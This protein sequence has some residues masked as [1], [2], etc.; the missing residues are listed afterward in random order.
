MGDGL[1]PVAG[2]ASLQWLAGFRQAC[3]LH[4]VALFCLSSRKLLIRLGQCFLL[5]GLIFLGSLFFLNK[6]VIPMLSWI[7]P[8]QCKELAF[9]EICDSGAVIR[10]YSVLRSI[11]INLFYVFWFCPLYVLS[12]ILSSIWYNDIAK[13]TFEIFRQQSGDSDN[14]GAVVGP[15]SVNHADKPTGIEGV[16]I[17]ISEQVYSALLLTIFYIEVVVTGYIPVIGK[18]INFVLLSWAYAYYSFEYKWNFSGLSLDKRL[19]LFELN[20]AFFA[21]FGSPCILGIFFFPP[22]T[23]YGVLA[24]LFPLFILVAIGTPEEQVITSQ[25]RSWKGEG[26]TKLPIFY[27]ANILSM[28]VLQLF[29][30]TDKKGQ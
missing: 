12:F 16:I 2:R 14:E 26:P 6:V 23:S 7:L 17:G 8:D 20:W 18:A 9:Q 29:P 1:L 24:I 21:G 19:K 5:N 3:C 22:L 10:F 27:A 28:K 15:H 25:R 11:L 4:R 13:L 30:E